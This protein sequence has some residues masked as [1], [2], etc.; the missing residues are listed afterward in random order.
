MTTKGKN[1]TNTGNKRN[2]EQDIPNPV[3]FERLVST[4]YKA[5]P[6][7]KSVTTNHEREVKFGT[8]GIKPYTKV[9]YDNVVG[10]LKSLGFTSR[11]EEGYYLMRIA[12]ELLD[13]S[14]KFKD[15]NIR[16]ELTGFRAI[17]EYCKTNDISKLLNNEQYM[18]SVKFVKKTPIYE[19]NEKIRDV[20]FKDF[21]FRVSYRKEEDYSASNIM[22]RGAI[23]NWLQMKKTF[24][25]INR[26]SFT[27]PDLPVNID[28]SI[29]KSSPKQG[30][31]MK[32]M[33]TTDEAGVFNN[34]EVYEFEIEV[35]N[36]RIGPGTDFG[37]PSDILASVRKAI[38]NVLMG[39]QG[40]N[41]PVSVVVQNESAQAY[42]SLIHG[43]G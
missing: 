28:M 29:V 16:T 33:Y 1:K 36:S 32:K 12:Y 43:K 40:T 6:F 22:I 14:G 8:K 11:Y 26:V 5:E 2:R 37:T 30:Y 13:K 35:D 15:S 20:N 39:L 23:Q 3:L 27:H 31:D 9:D 38:K 21:N 19:N 25:Y 34:P 4:Y 10:K 7:V 41:Y 18:S 42:M 24:R 17:Q